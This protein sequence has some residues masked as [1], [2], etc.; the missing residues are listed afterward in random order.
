MIS[1]VANNYNSNKI[2]SNYSKSNSMVAAPKS[3]SFGRA[4][5]LLERD[6]FR[7]AAVKMLGKLGIKNNIMVIHSP[8]FAPEFSDGI[9]KFVDKGIGSSCDEGFKKFLKFSKDLFGIDGLQLGPETRL[10]R[11]DHSPYSNGAFSFSEHL[12]SP[13]KLFKENFIS[14]ATLNSLAMKAEKTS[15]GI[16]NVDYDKF[17]NGFPKIIDEAYDNFKKLAKD[18]ILKIKFEEF[19][20]LPQVKPWL[21]KDAIYHA[22]EQEYSK[23]EKEYGR[24]VNIFDWSDIDKKL[25]LYLEDKSLGKVKEAQERLLKLNQDHP[26]SI[27]KYEFAQFLVHRQ[28][29]DS[30]KIAEDMGQKLLGDVKIGNGMN[31]A[32]GFPRAFIVDLDKN[33]CS[34]V[35][36]SK[37]DKD[38]WGGIAL[39]HNTKEAKEF[40]KLKM[41]HTFLY[42]HGARIDAVFGYV[43]PFLRKRQY[44]P[45]KEIV[46]E[47]AEQV[48]QG[49]EL[50]KPIVES[51]RKNGIDIK[52]VPAE[53]LGSEAQIGLTRKILKD[54][55]IS[56]LH[57]YNPA[58]AR[59]ESAG[60]GYGYGNEY[61][62]DYGSISSS[63]GS[64][65]A[66]AYGDGFKEFI[67]LPVSKDEIEKFDNKWF[68]ASSHDTN[69]LI[70]RTAGDRSLQKEILA[71]DFLGSN[72]YDT[73]LGWRKQFSFM[74]AFGIKQRYNIP[75][76][77]KDS[78]MTRL[79]ENYEELYY[80]HLAEGYSS[81]KKGYNLPE[82]LLDAAEKKG[83]S[84]KT[85][86]L[87]DK[88][89]LDKLTKFKNILSEKGPYTTEEAE[90]MYAKS[91]PR[92]LQT[93]VV[94]ETKP[95]PVEPI[96]SDM[97]RKVS[98]KAVVLSS[99]SVAGVLSSVPFICKL[100]N[101][102]KIASNSIM[103]PTTP[104]QNQQKPVFSV[105]NI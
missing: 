103:P 94:A 53:N 73:Q 10:T 78:W 17:F 7:T 43:Q 36:C 70:N 102:Q 79:P 14:E 18:N 57:N 26:D 48:Y 66:E 1:S 100:I 35:A 86:Q 60:Y 92:T 13:V 61:G 65:S 44:A 56:E 52:L 47:V 89:L 50:I 95:T 6:E 34:T 32:W 58:V 45:G 72:S 85:H 20:L 91:T 4:L 87:Y 30:K 38:D 59:V 82:I 68:A 83:I 29:M 41:D 69:T 55:G 24:E 80:K 40:L 5:T 19:K 67:K 9:K 62:S 12:L 21:E 75:R 39:N 23:L 64:S 15:E 16:L 49:D 81:N 76:F 104:E 90:K 96:S 98:K 2:N 101:R 33:T 74:D 54:N 28:K 22:L 31:D 27:E 93:V 97:N 37:V 71:N 3:V 63:G 84:K 77:P 105:F 42:N 99:I 51:I 8:S 11:V 46:K 25:N 88:E